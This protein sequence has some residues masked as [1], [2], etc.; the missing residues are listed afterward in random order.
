MK[1]DKAINNAKNNINAIDWYM[2]HYKPTIPQQA[3]LPKHNLSKLPAE[4]QYRKRSAVF[5]KEVNTMN[6]FSFELGTQEN[7]VNPI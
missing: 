2:S 5:L 6:L 4:F 3:L 1:K 7:K